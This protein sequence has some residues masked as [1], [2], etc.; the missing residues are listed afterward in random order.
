MILNGDAL[1][2]LRTLPDCSV[3]MACTSPPYYGLRSYCD[4]GSAEKTHEIG[5]ESSPQEYITKMVS[6]FAEVRRVL[7]D[8]GS[9][10]LNIGDS[11]NAAG[12]TGHGTREGCKQG[13]N[14][15]SD[16][17]ADN[18]R[19]SVANLKEKDLIG[20]P[21]ML[22]FA[23]RADGW[24]LRSDII[25]HKPN[26]MPESV[27]DRP[28]K[29]HEYL[30]LLTKSAR[31]YYD[32]EA[33]KEPLTESSMERYK[34]G[35][36]GDKKRGWP[37]EAQNNFDKYMG[38]EKAMAATN[39]NKRSVWTINTHSYREAHFATFPEALVEPCIK[40]GSKIDDVILDPFA[41]SG[42]TLA[43]AKRLGRKFIGIELNPKY[44]TLIER[45]LSQVV[46]QG[47]LL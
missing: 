19:P 5:L 44:I 40:A 24:Y 11:Y 32:N 34:S 46:Y 45:R 20:I 14:R 4:A 27:T 43:V 41:G 1:T 10:W 29:S 30:F 35:W 22:A 31:Y 33:I 12:R 39:R 2:M 17:G 36:N 15:A 13:T 23:L 47:S 16:T 18:C 21:W 3:Q 26:P 38:S 6:V 8:N 7:R 37:G 42:T 25:W 9:L 28:T